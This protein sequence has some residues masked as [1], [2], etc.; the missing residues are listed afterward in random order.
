MNSMVTGNYCIPD[1]N[2]R[3]SERSKAS[4][5]WDLA[6][7]TA[8]NAVQWSN[9]S[10]KRIEGT[11]MGLDLHHLAGLLALLLPVSSVLKGGISNL[12]ISSSWMLMRR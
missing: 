7:V 11:H 4:P 5:P 8:K 10:A 1:G 3:F 2:R 9:V 6:T 12:M